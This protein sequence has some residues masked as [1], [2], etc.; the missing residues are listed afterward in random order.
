MNELRKTGILLKERM[1]FELA[2]LAAWPTTGGE[3]RFAVST[4]LGL[5]PPE[6][7]NTVKV[8]GPL[9]ILSVAP[10]R[11]LIVRPARTP[12]LRDELSA[13]VASDTAA[14]VDLSAGRCVFTISGERSRELLSKHL[15]LDLSERQFSAGRCAQSAI[16]RI[17]V[18]LH[19]E[20]RNM[21]AIY[22][23]RSLAQ[24]LSEMLADSA[25]AM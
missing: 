21:L 25:I 5:E 14:V 23:C 24:H 2:H 3:A 11:W 6:R 16:G 20:S 17:D 8:L 13:K 1:G 19:A 18:L 12:S 4:M 15:P 7:P 9:K 22:V 10:H